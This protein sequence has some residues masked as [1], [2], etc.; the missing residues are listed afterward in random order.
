MGESL[1][2][3]E[4]GMLMDAFE[5][6]SD[7][8][9]DEIPFTKANYDALFSNGV[10]TPMGHVKMGENQ[11][12]KFSNLNRTYQLAMAVKTL[13][14]PDFVTEKES[15]AKKGQEPERPSSYI[16]GKV[17]NDGNTKYI[18]YNSVSV[19][20]DGLEVVIS[21]YA[22]ERKRLERELREGKLAYIKEV[23]L[24]SESGTSAQ[25]DQNTNLAGGFSASKDTNSSENSNISDENNNNSETNSRFRTSEQLDRE[26]PGWNETDK[27]ADG[28]HSTQI[29]GTTSTYRKVGQP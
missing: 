1:S 19:L 2:A 10:D 6:L 24:P 7:K 3:V 12:D 26:Y 18:Y 11:F 5:V 4:S 27:N 15:T 9:P 8:L 22:P 16:Y 14:S 25:G 13:S 29:A 28:S 23:T 20:K 21:N 17:F